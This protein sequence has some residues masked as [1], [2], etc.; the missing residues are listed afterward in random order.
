MKQKKMLTYGLDFALSNK[1]LK[2]IIACLGPKILTEKVEALFVF[3]FILQNKTST[4]SSNI[5]GSRHSTITFKYLF[6][7]TKSVL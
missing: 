5:F 1:Y 2:V 4:L 6:D 3:D 7:R